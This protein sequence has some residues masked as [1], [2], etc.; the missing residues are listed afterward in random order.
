[1][2][3]CVSSRNSWTRSDPSITRLRRDTRVTNNDHPSPAPWRVVHT[4]LSMDLAV[5]RVTTT[6]QLHVEPVEGATFG[7]LVLDGRGLH[8]HEVA[9]DGRVLEAQQFQLDERRLVIDL[10]TVPCVVTTVVSATP[11]A[12]NDKGFVFGDGILSTNLE[13]EGFRRLTWFLDRPSVR[14]TFDVTL[15]GDSQSFPYLRCNGNLLESGFAADGRVFARFVDPVPK[16]SYLFSMVAGDLR[17]RS[18][19]FA[20]Q[21]GR[22]ITLTVAAPPNMIDG[23]DFALW[24][25]PE[26]L[27]FDE[28]NGGV[29]H[30]LDELVFVAVP[31]YPDATEYHGL[32]FFDP[33]LLVVD[34]RGFVDDDLMLVALN[35]AHEYGH[36]TRGNRV[37]VQTWGEL[38]LKEGLTVLTAQNDFRAHLFGPAARILDVLD[39]R[40]LQFPEEITI[41]A[42]VMRGEVADPASLYNRT[43]YLKGAEIFGMMRTALGADRWR[44]AFAGFVSRHDLG[45]AT[46]ADFITVARQVAPSLG[47]EIDAIARWFPRAGR[48]SVEIKPKPEGVRLRRIDALSDEPC[49]GMPVALGFLSAAGAPLAVSIDDGPS[50]TEHVVTLAERERHLAVASSEPF[51]VSPLRRYSAPVDL[52]VDM[53]NDHLALLVEHDDDAYARWWAAQELMIRSI[54]AHRAGD[55]GTGD[56]TIAVLTDTLSRVV[57]TID[58]PVLLAQ[59]LAVPDEF[60]LGDRDP[61][62]DVDGV[63]SGL[64]RLRRQMGNALH[65]VLIDVWCRFDGDDLD[66]ASPSDM[67]VRMLVEPVLAPLLATASGDGT[68]LA[69]AA[70]D[71]RNAT[72]A[73]R[74]FA[75]LAHVDHAPFDDLVA[76]QYDVWKGAPKLIDRWLRAQSGARRSDTI[77]RVAALASGPLY[78][79]DDRS[80]V[81]G[82]W[83]PFA[84]RN[85]VVFHHPS[86][87]GYRIFV[88]ELGDLMPTNAGLAV[89]LVGDLLQFKRFDERRSALMRAELERMVHMDGMPGF[90]VDILHGLLA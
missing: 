62:I 74:A 79:R 90:A 4:V 63:A 75:Q 87:E 23:A 81:M 85:R 52:V 14:S 7:S 67:A 46:V 41:G 65:D 28:A 60:M 84:T 61:V 82:V 38:T 25:M 19:Q 15:I 68:R 39:L 47:D 13:P 70:L 72:R 86:G 11:G 73:M 5:D 88:D 8:T 77:A 50:A 1:M 27:A 54:D 89:R 33:S 35:A 55:D 3:W 51:V 66:G 10:P 12:P 37:T 49:L 17:T 59:L 78:D 6:A 32:M 76:R 36:H 30:D 45:A 71:S 29:P 48:P 21:S 40:R 16:P 43:T 80:R 22:T 9:V 2:K 53:S 44:E 26:V 31:G 24:V 69:L 20:S 57:P 34:T 83:F 18:T 58:D 42:P 56:A 64:E